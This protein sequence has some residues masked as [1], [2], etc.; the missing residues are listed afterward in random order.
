MQAR[1]NELGR[2]CEELAVD[3]ARLTDENSALKEQLQYVQ[4]LLAGNNPTAPSLRHSNPPPA[5]HEGRQQH[6]QFART[7]GPLPAGTE[8][9]P[10]FREA[11]EEIRGTSPLSTNSP[12][13][14]TMV[15]GD[16]APTPGG[17]SA[18]FGW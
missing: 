15:P 5:Q 13:A 14:N 17:A 11:M 3:K 16:L 2:M 9:I 4:D 6:P 8:N 18:D 10:G 7:G 12:L 1:V